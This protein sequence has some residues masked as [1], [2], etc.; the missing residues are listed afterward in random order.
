[1]ATTTSTNN[2]LIADEEQAAR[3]AANAET[4]SA[5]GAR[6]AELLWARGHRALQAPLEGAERPTIMALFTDENGCRYPSYHDNDNDGD[7]NNDDNGSSSKTSSWTTMTLMKKRRQQP[8]VATVVLFRMGTNRRTGEHHAPLSVL[9]AFTRGDISL[10]DNFDLH[11]GATLPVENCTF[12]AAK[13]LLE[14]YEARAFVHSWTDAQV[15]RSLDGF[16]A[17]RFGGEDFSKRLD[18]AL[19][20]PEH[21]DLFR[22]IDSQPGDA[23]VRAYF[24]A[25]VMRPH[26][27]GLDA[28]ALRVQAKQRL[29]P[30]REPLLQFVHARAE[31][32]E[33]RR[34]LELPKLEPF[35]AIE[36]YVEARAP[37]AGYLATCNPRLSKLAIG[38]GVLYPLIAP[39]WDDL[40]AMWSVFW[41]RRC[42]LAH[43]P[44]LA[45]L[46]LMFQRFG[47]H[48]EVSKDDDVWAVRADGFAKED[49]GPLDCFFRGDPLAACHLLRAI[50]VEGPRRKL[51]LANQLVARSLVH[52]LTADEDAAALHAQ[53]RLTAIGWDRWFAEHVLPHLGDASAAS[54]SATTTV[55]N[56]KM[57][58]MGPFFAPDLPADLVQAVEDATLDDFFRLIE[59]LVDRLA[60]L[61]L[62]PA[63]TT[64]TTTTS[65]SCC[66]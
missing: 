49:E 63:A 50:A 46:F 25:E 57:K 6:V 5:Y 26:F 23:D 55:Q 59:G 29:D 43:S 36:A 56:K 24:L 32:M 64:T 16:A 37:L 40:L 34:T 65:P 20:H 39:Q 44:D 27:A 62:P 54:A 1:M 8:K 28:K 12:G 14:A 53:R 61:P 18:D 4:H 45:Y 22:L 3:A 42:M 10:S 31:A 47:I 17:I 60:L 52:K 21:R 33:A 9:T 19:A 30:A 35:A 13:L 7:H 2:N 58:I 41:A 66:S 48:A 15:R 51:G 11:A 38:R